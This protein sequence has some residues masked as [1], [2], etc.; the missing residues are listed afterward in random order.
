MGGKIKELLKLSRQG[1]PV[2]MVNARKK[3]RME[4]AFLHNPC[5]G[6]WIREPL[7]SMGPPDFPKL[8]DYRKE[9]TKLS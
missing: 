9:T 3:K 7:P 8:K 2:L 6:T 1:I 4:Q 5:I